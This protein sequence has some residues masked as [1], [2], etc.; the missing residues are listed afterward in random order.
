MIEKLLHTPEGVRDI[1]NEECERKL[2]LQNNLHHIMKLHGFHDIQTPTFE[3]FDIFSKERG[4][5]PAKDMY[6]F[7]DRD[8]NTLVLRPDITPS[9]A[10]CAA[11]YY[12][13]EEFPIRLCYIGSTF[14]NNSSYQGK[15][16]E[17]TQL[18]AEL[19]N[20]STSDADAQ[21]LALTIECLL[22]AGLK[23]FQV[24]IGEADFFRGL[25]DEAGFDEEEETQLRILIEKKN[26][27]G[28]EELLSSKDISSDLKLVFLTLP[29][30]FGTLDKLT[31]AKTLTKNVRALKAIERLEQINTILTVYGLEK[32][33][34]FDLGM[35]SKYNYYTGIIFR[36][37]T[38]GTGDTIANGGRYDNLV[39][40]FGKNAP[41]IGLAILVDQLMLALSRQK[42][43][44]KSETENTLILYK[45]NLLENAIVLANHFRKT[46][47]NIELLREA[48]NY[49]LDD[50]IAYSKRNGIGGILYFETPELI[51]VIR[52]ES[53]D[54]QEASIKDF[55]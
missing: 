7:F 12:K 24:E 48:A 37:Y 43:E 11:K 33:I 44:I 25:V 47:V 51:K 17:S 40:Q 34:T 53:G 30:L 29:E 45:S 18:G 20:D 26:M 5:V 21:M 2:Q 39:G 36:A 50:Y 31:Y 15:L 41:A 14:I 55:M 22:Q 32:Y 4:T 46:G 54:I 23:E 13:N 1:Y 19:I 8:G 35:L 49:S 3:F 6:K 27:F 42:I 38:Y 9:I 52:S 16:K 28:V 10:R